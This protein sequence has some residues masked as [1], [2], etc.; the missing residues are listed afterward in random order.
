MIEP[1]LPNPDTRESSTRATSICQPARPL[2]SRR[3]F[4][5]LAAGTTLSAALAGC[6][7]QARSPLRVRVLNDALPP[8]I[9]GQ[10]QR[11]FK[12]SATNGALEIER[13]PQLQAL[14][15]LLQTWK[16]QG[17][18]PGET[19]GWSLP[20]ISGT[21][22]LADW[23]SLGDYWLEKAIQQRLIQPIDPAAFKN[24]TQL[25]QTAQWQALVKRNEQ[26]QIDPQGKVWGA[27]Y[28][29]GTTVIA[30]RRDLL[31][32][33]GIQ[34][35]TDWADLWRS[36]LR[37]QISLPDQAREVIG[38]TLKKLGKSYNLPDLTAVPNLAAELRALRPQVKLYSSTAYLQ[39]LLLGDTSVAVGWSTDVLP[40]L[41]RAEQIEIVVP[42]SGT[43]LWAELWVR[44]AAATSAGP[45]VSDWVNF[46]WQQQIATQLSLLSH[47]TS[48]IVL[49][50]DPNQLPL[51]LRQNPVLFPDA[52]I[53]AKSE[54]LQPLSKATVEQYR[55]HWQHLLQAG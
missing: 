26:G 29:Y 45:G 42:K 49:T 51:D 19:T 7:S 28:R 10:V 53:L 15:A 21:A 55:T 30:Y 20:G 6:G 37:G 18:K 33:R 11:A 44:P 9:I 16:Q 12:Q 22:P 5:T 46:Y 2:Y 35:P 48:P 47:A 54:F 31:H 4:L 8:Q 52:A 23:V 39:P 27:P 17:T 38:L 14:F 50:I 36:E 32:D 41:Q 24:W 43:A 3:S 34:P 13:E 1:T 25:P 40:L